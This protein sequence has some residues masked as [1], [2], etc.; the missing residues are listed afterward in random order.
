MDD[1]GLPLE[2]DPILWDWGDEQPEEQPEEQADDVP[3]TEKATGHLDPEQLAE[4]D[5][6]DLKKLAAD[7]GVKP[8]GK[9]KADYIAALVAVEV[10]LGDEADPDEDDEDELPEL[11][12]A[13]PE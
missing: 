6:N 1:L 8:T 7:M 13:D 3:E 10:E 5:Y 2:A 9:S 4:M 12:V 11:N